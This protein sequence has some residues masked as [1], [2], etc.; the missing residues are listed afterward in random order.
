[1]DGESMGRS[2]S[3][4][5]L[6]Q[7]HNPYKGREGGKVDRPV[8]STFPASHPYI[9]VGKVGRSKQ[10]S[11]LAALLATGYVR[12]LTSGSRHAHGASPQIPLASAGEESD[13]LAAATAGKRLRCKQV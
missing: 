7:H 8:D 4:Y 13:E 12:L 2:S 1:M 10:L 6:S 9:E 5:R 3:R 11:S